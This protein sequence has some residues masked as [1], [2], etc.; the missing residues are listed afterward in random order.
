MSKIKPYIISKQLVM[1]AYQCVKAN[2]GAAG[3]D[4]QSLESFDKDLKDNLYKIWN[5]ISSGTYFPP[6]V[7]AVPIPKKT[8]GERILG[9]PTVA[10]R[11]AQMV[12]KLT[13]EPSVEPYFH[14]DSYGYRP[15]KSAL[16]A[17]GV[18]RK[19][20]WK[21]D[22]VLEFDIKG[23]FDNIKHDLLLKAVRKHNDNPWVIL[24]IERWLKAPMQMP[25]GT[26]VERTKG[27]PQGGVISPVLSNLFLH[28]VFDVWMGKHHPGK[29]WC[30][31]AD[32]GLV[33]LRSEAEAQVLLANLQHRFEMC[34]LELHP[35]KTKIV[36]CKDRS[37]RSKYPTTQFTFLGY[38]FRSR[39]SLNSRTNEVFQNFMPA[40]SKSAAKS[41]R[42]HIRASRMRNRTEL[43]LKE[44]ADRYNPILR[45]WIGYYGCYYKS[46]LDPV[47][48]HFNKT[49]VAWAMRKYKKL[50]GHRTRASLF[51]KKI[52]KE[53]PDLFIHWKQG[54]GIGFA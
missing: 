35:L 52:Q 4:K 40:V 5:R 6:P 51:I 11:I 3:V 33:H 31:Y 30:R 47:M 41:M 13:F 7:K 9:I 14:E 16:D 48:L 15:N 45:G 25:D 8:G 26:L 44:I 54:Y 34:G 2:K 21:Y 32:D 29:P 28:Y 24:Y 37:R 18:T 22:F 1:E 49:L 39:R 43:S 38:D 12:V 36:Y 20:C 53:S 50:K 27:T 42:A 17:I 23:L 19:R 10:D 46:A